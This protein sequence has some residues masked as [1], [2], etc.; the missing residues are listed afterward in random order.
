MLYNKPMTKKRFTL[1]CAVYLVLIK[2]N[3]LLIQR[4]Y[5]TGWMDGRYSLISGHLEKGET[6]FKAM[7]RETKEESGL[8]LQ[9]KDLKVIHVLHRKSEDYEYIDIFF[10]ANRWK[11]NPQVIERDKSDKLVWVP[12][13]KLPKL[14]LGHIRQM[15][16]C[17]LKKIPFSEFGFKGE[18][19]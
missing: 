14:L 3:K 5:K 13:N 12:L 8:N 18:S 9:E 1:R 11:G 2:N 7:V 10:M 16:A 4:R 19:Y 15:V 6:A 17:Y